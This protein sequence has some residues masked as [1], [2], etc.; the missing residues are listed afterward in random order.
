MLVMEELI[1]L[2]LAC[3]AMSARDFRVD[4][5]NVPLEDLLRA[6]ISPPLFQDLCFRAPALGEPPRYGPRAPRWRHRIGTLSEPFL[7]GKRLRT[8]GE[9]PAGQ[10]VHLLVSDQDPVA[11]AAE[12][13]WYDL[14][15]PFVSES[16][17]AY[18]LMDLAAL[19]QERREVIAAFLTEPEEARR[20]FS[21]LCGIACLISPDWDAAPVGGRELEELVCRYRQAAP[22]NPVTDLEMQTLLAA[23]G[24]FLPFD[25][26]WHWLLAFWALTHGSPVYR[27]RDP[28]AVLLEGP[29]GLLAERC[30]AAV[31]TPEAAARLAP[32]LWEAGTPRA[33]QW[34]RVLLTVRCQLPE[35]LVRRIC[36]KVYGAPLTERSLSDLMDALDSP[37]A[38]AVKRSLEELYKWEGMLHREGF[39]EALAAVLLRTGQAPGERALEAV[40]EGLVRK[41]RG[42]GLAE[43][44]S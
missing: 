26:R 10:R 44:G 7:Q 5:G 27:G 39:G 33:Q 18:A 3:Y 34:L 30:L 37:N 20:L 17:K 12:D 11:L 29:Q 1:C 35:A 23:S 14:L 19:G 21:G 43:E 28:A 36:R 41:L 24:V 6:R 38:Q 16:D 22:E 42:W 13:R 4:A 9:I 15:R 2:Y 8:V 32:G 31:C 25:R 40:T